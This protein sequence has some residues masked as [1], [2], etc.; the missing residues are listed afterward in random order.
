MSLPD[1]LRDSQSYTNFLK[2]KL[3]AQRLNI[4]FYNH[5]YHLLVVLFN[6]LFTLYGA[7]EL[8]MGVVRSERNPVRTKV[9]FDLMEHRFWITIMRNILNIRSDG[10]SFWWGFILTGFRSVGI[11]FCRV[12]VLTGFRSHGP[13]STDG[14]AI[15]NPDMIWHDYKKYTDARMRARR[16]SS[17]TGTRIARNTD[18]RRCCPINPLLV[19]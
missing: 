8:R 5:R 19:T 3:K 7:S 10:N 11:S 12:F 15:A 17:S 6:F 14:G 2:S 4:A 13:K 16:R 1:N 9:V 18:R